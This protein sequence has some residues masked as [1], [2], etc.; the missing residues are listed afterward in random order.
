MP[1]AFDAQR[2]EREERE[3]ARERAGA[4]GLKNEVG[5]ESSGAAGDLACLKR[6]LPGWWPA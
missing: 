6:S 5:R 4:G 2:L 3:Q 1:I